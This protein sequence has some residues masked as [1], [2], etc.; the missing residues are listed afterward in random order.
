MKNLSGDEQMTYNTL[1][2]DIRTGSNSTRCF[3]I[4]RLK[5]FVEVMLL[6]QY[7]YEEKTQ[8]DLL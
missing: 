8:K 3:N 6:A 7:G 4:A 2:M 1:L 5:E